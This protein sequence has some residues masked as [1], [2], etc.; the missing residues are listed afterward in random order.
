MQNQF[1]LM[2]VICDGLGYRTECENNPL[3]DAQ[4]PFFKHAL[5]YYPHTFLEASGAA[6]GLLPGMKGNSAVGHLTIGA[7]RII[8]RPIAAINRMI[9]DG[10]FFDNALLQ[11]R[12]NQLAQ[13]GKALHIF[14]MLSDGN[15]HSN[16]E[17]M[18][19]FVQMALQCGVKKIILHAF[20]DGI[21]VAPR[22]AAGYL[23]K[24][25]TRFPQVVIGS[26]AGRAYAMDRA[27]N[28]QYIERVYATFTTPLHDNNTWQQALENYYATTETSDAFFTPLQLSSEGMIEEGD[29]L[30]FTNIRAD[31]MRELTKKILTS[32]IKYNFC[33]TAIEYDPHFEA[34]VFYKEPLVHETLLDVLV[35]AH[36]K[37]FTIA[38][39]E[40]YAHITYFFSGGRERVHPYEKRILVPSLNKLSYD[41]APE[42]S[43]Q[44]ITDHVCAAVKRDEADFYLINYANADMVGHSGNYDATVKALEC[45]DKQLQQLYECFVVQHK[46][47][48]YITADHGNAELKYQGSIDSQSTSHTLNKVPFIMIDNKLCDPANEQEQNKRIQELYGLADIAPFILHNLNIAIPRVMQHY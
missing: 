27:E 45:L 25:C 28:V 24:F 21:D 37:I 10:S 30:L 4:M 33:I 43:A 38:E 42:M 23:K 3:C 40:K 34:D 19:A 47:T 15:S 39:T 11:K 9:Q 31:R 41:I 48:L 20:L 12:F 6:V 29:G 46:G 7:G 13:S 22:S 18:A 36:K 17:Q 8:E 32:S 44:Q 14:G 26:L 35:A 5:S 1:P 16:D 2:L